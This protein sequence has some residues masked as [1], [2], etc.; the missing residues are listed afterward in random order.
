MQPL[1]TALINPSI[2]TFIQLNKFLNM[3]LLLA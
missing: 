3:Y 1:Y 2:E